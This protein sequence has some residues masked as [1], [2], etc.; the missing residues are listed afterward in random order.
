MKYLIALAVL[1]AGLAC[2]QTGDHCAV[3]DSLKLVTDVP[4][5]CRSGVGETTSQIKNPS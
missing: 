4:Y 2:C 1:L 5:I 3:L